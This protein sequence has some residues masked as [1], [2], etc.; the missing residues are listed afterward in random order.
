MDLVTGVVRAAIAIH[1]AFAVVFLAA[2]A[3]RP[4]EPEYGVLAAMSAAVALL[5]AATV[6]E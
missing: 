2:R 3:R 1:A 4:Q 6:A 5:S